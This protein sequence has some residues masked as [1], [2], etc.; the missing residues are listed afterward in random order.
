MTPTNVRHHTYQIPLT[1]CRLSSTGRQSSGI[2]T[3]TSSAASAKTLLHRV[4]GICKNKR[5][6]WECVGWGKMGRCP[7]QMCNKHTPY[8]YKNSESFENNY[9][10]LPTW[11]NHFNM[12]C[13]NVSH[14]YLDSSK[15]VWAGAK[16]VFKIHHTKYNIFKLWW[17]VGGF[18]SYRLSSEQFVLAAVRVCCGLH[19]TQS[20]SSNRTVSAGSEHHVCLIEWRRSVGASV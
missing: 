9:D 6:Y 17:R 19:R 18:V 12:S 3:A 20:G 1:C 7:W 15:A 14:F 11:P 5:K 16:Q 13:L 4:Q 8:L 2:R 10:L